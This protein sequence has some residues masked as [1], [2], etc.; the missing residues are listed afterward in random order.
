MSTL[1]AR[2]EAAGVAYLKSISPGLEA[3]VVPGHIPTDKTAPLVVFSVRTMTEEPPYSG[4]FRVSCTVEVKQHADPAN[5]D[6]DD[7]LQEAVL[8]AIWVND[9]ADQLTTNKG[10]EPLVIWSASAP[11]QIEHSTSDD[12]WIETLTLEL[13]AAQAG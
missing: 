2:I 8:G 12:F 4:N 6:P 1:R 3:D 10:L 9:L 13:Y 11:L 7:T 5:Y